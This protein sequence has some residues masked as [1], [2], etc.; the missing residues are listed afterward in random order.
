MNKPKSPRSGFTLIELLTVIAIIGIL[1]GI[2]IPTVGAVQKKAAMISS[3]NNLKQIAIAYITFSSSGKRT[4]VISK[5]SWS[6][7]SNRSA[8]NMKDWAKVLAYNAQLTDASIWFIGSDENVSGYSGTLPRSI[9]I[10][11]GAEFHESS[12]WSQIPEDIISY[13]AVVDMSALASP[14]TPL[15]WTK[16]LSLNGEW[17]STSPWLG[18]GGHMVFMDGHVE[19]FENLT[20]DENKLTPGSASGTNSSTS[21]ISVAIKTTSKTDY[22][23]KN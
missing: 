20:A 12:E 16:G 15:A 19:F 22:L 10:K 2:I 18:E 11:D 1:A 23:L 4:R 13:S 9:G 5:G 3:V 21:N 14:T 6:T 8:N 7:S 17:A